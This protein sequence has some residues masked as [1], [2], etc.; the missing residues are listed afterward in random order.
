MIDLVE[1]RAYLMR[2]AF[3]V[4]AFPSVSE[5]FVL[6]QITGLLDRGHE[7]DIFASRPELVTSLQ[8][9]VTRYRLMERTHYWASLPRTPLRRVL[10]GGMQLIRHLHR[11]PLKLIQSLWATKLNDWPHSHGLLSQALAMRGTQ[12][13]EVIHC[14]FGPTGLLALSLRRLGLLRGRILTT[15]HGHDVTDDNYHHGKMFY[16]LLFDEGDHFTVNTEHLRQ[17]LLTIGCASGKISRLLMGIPLQQFEFRERRWSPGEPIHILTVGRLHE[18]KGLEYSIVAMAQVLQ[19]HPNVVYRIVGDG[20]L[21]SHLQDLIVRHRL[22]DHVILLGS[23]TRE[24]VAELYQ[25]AHI[26]MLTSVTTARGYPESQGVVLGEAQACGLPIIASR[27]GGIPEMVDDGQAGFLVPERN[28]DAIADR[29]CY[30]IEHPELWPDMG[31]HGRAFV[32]QQL[33]L[34]LLNDRLV[35]I[36]KQMRHSN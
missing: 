34:N 27:S 14:H 11:S 36:Y 18:L 8:E 19:R 29:L 25:T 9:D 22:S 1:G 5:T 12:A 35:D 7:V 30:L 4:P 16:R 31:Q 6:Q 20:P 15:F 17:R 24:E 2:I 13:Y 28:V 3:M 23:R 10:A 26:F 32:E 33:D 21:R